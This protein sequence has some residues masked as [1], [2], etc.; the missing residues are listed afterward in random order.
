MN[1]GAG[2]NTAAHENSPNI[3][4]DHKTIYYQAGEHFTQYQ[5]LWSASRDSPDEQFGDALDL[6]N[7]LNGDGIGDQRSRRYPSI[8]TDQ[9][10]LFFEIDDP[11]NRD[12]WVS[13]R[14]NEGVFG[15]PTRVEDMWPGSEINSES[16]DSYPFISSNWPTWGAKLYFASDRIRAGQGD[17]FQA[18]WLPVGDCDADTKLSVAD[19]SCVET[20]LARDAVLNWLKTFPGDLDGNGAVEFAD[21]LVLSANFNHDTPR[22]I[23]GNINLEGGVDFADFLV[24]SANFGRISNNVETVPEPA[25]L[26]SD[27]V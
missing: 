15:H 11:T 10:F 13:V 16:L 5:R 14:S 19:L 12:I 17:I 25:G 20:I 26:G 27:S 7:A 2:V 21:F 18:T 6:G 1:L 8:S 9:R 22:Y 3:S 4:V 24:L 23:D